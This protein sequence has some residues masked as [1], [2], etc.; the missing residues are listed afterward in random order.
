[1]SPKASKN[2][3]KTAISKMASSKVFKGSKSIT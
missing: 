2:T 3:H 1:M